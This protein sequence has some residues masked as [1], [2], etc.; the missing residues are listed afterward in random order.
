MLTN[1]LLNDRY[2]VKEAVGG[3]GMANVYLAYDLIL[4]REV[5]IKVL[6]LEYGN[7]EEFIARF[8]REAQS[9]TSLAHSNIVNIY[10]VG[11]EEDLYYMV[12]EYVDGMTLKQY[13]QQ[14]SPI[15]P[16]EAI[17]I[18]KQVTSAIT[19]AH[20]N[21]I[22]HRDIKPQNILIDHYGHVKVTDFGIAMALSAT[23]LTQTNSVLGSVH[24][25]SPEQARG[26]TATKKSDI[27][28]LGIVFFELLTGR[29][30]FSGQSPV[31]I[32]LKHLQHDTPSLKRWIPDLPQSVENVV[33]KSTA[34]D[35][36]HRYDSVM[37]M[38]QDLET[39]LNPERLNEPAFVPPDEEDEEKTKAIPVITD[40]DF[41]D[42]EEGETIVHEA[43]VPDA[44]PEE[45]TKKA[46]GKSKKGKKKKSEKP[47]KK[48]RW[49]VWLLTIFL[50]LIL[51]G[52][53]ILFALPNLLEPD[54]VEMIDVTGMEY[55]EAYSQLREL[56]LDVQRE[57]VFS[58]DVEEGSV[59][60]TD[61]E[62]GTMIKEQ[63][64]VT[65][66]SSKGKERIT[67]ED[68]VGQ[69]Y[70]RIK[71]ELDEQGFANV[72]AIEEN[73]DRPRG[74]IIEQIQP[75]AGDEVVAEDTRVIFRVSLGPPL[76]TLQP[77][78]GQT[79]DEARQYLSDNGLEV[80]VSEEYS[81]DVP[82][83]EI[84]RQEPAALTEV[85][86]GSTVSIV[87][88]LGPEPVEEEETEEPPP[89]EESPEE[90][91]P[92]EAPE[93]E[94]EEEESEEAVNEEEPR[95]ETV[96][97]EVPFNE[98][99]DKE[100][101]TVLIY[102]EDANNQ[103]SEVYQEETITEDTTIEFEITIEPGEEASYKVQLEDEVIEQANVSY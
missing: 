10:D 43:G 56:N 74:E 67:F 90:E 101:Q 16:A 22:V 98:E 75:Q 36:F 6:R 65:V 97:V 78:E 34:K 64:R 53:A 42:Q 87:V 54:D 5:A 73:S 7:D 39:S 83:G 93:E 31:S 60:R 55:E 99:L 89:E 63:S 69:S 49:W 32:A 84:I 37:E 66:Y 103:I 47:K 2:K 21:D 9:A 96:S 45:P 95:E 58:D 4:K 35:P 28:S 44:V 88:S 29:L 61:P 50:V 94:P 41:G 14:N 72:L 11:E 19:H 13:I 25:L 52:A 70:E 33:F 8:H 18:M 40:N 86:R 59:V 46:A 51:A 57:T 1:R 91:A 48:R 17:D 80:S 68:Y 23:A 85:E 12:M 27:Y 26:G 71:E 102:V 38:E 79:E 62:A 3:G 24:Y 76:I 15:D 100:E 77:L 30:P 81:S 82:E 20:D 92:E